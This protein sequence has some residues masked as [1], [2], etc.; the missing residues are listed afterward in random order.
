MNLI[1]T[2]R[3]VDDIESC[4]LWSAENFGIPAAHRYRVLLEV[5][6]LAIMED[7]E[8]PGSKL[9]EGFDGNVRLYHLRLSRKAAP[10]GGLIVKNPRHFIVYRATEDGAI[11]LLRVLHERMDFDTRMNGR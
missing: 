2:A 10:V 8:L 7:P 11:E 1:R 5:A 6:L 4:L 3:A 9:A